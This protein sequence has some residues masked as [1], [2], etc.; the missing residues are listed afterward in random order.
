MLTGYL[1]VFLEEVF[2]PQN[3]TKQ[4]NQTKPGG[5]REAQTLTFAAFP[6]YLVSIPSIH[7]VTHNLLY[8]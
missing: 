4:P 8:L 2:F 7:V 1:Y 6:E 3:K 5:W